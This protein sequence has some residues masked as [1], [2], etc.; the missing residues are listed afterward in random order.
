MPPSKLCASM[1]CVCVS[2]CCTFA[3][4]QKKNVNLNGTSRNAAECERWKSSFANTEHF[5]QEQH[6]MMSMLRMTMRLWW[7]SWQFRSKYLSLSARVRVRVCVLVRLT[8]VCEEC[9]HTCSHT[10]Y[11]NICTMHAKV[12]KLK[13]RCITQ[14]P[15]THSYAW[16]PRQLNIHEIYTP[17]TFTLNF[18]IKTNFF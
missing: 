6:G 8:F 13:Q 14:H 4:V 5:S 7:F 18:Y 12:C 9:F 1:L 10:C 16:T 17:H 11:I 15:R 2:V 3:C